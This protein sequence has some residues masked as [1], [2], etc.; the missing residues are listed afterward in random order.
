MA[1][2]YTQDQRIGSLDTPL[3]Q[4]VLVLLSFEGREVVNEGFEYKVEALYNE[5]T[6]RGKI[7][8]FD[9]AI[10]KHCTL[11]IKTRDGGLRFIDGIL[12]EARWLDTREEGDRY[13]LVLRS[14]LWVL[15]KR[16]NSLIFHDKTAPDIITEIFGAH[17]GIA[18]FR[19]A[20]TKSYPTL[21]YV[22]QYRES[23]RDFVCRL[24]EEHG[25]SLHFEHS[26][27]AHKLVMGDSTSAYKDM[28]ARTF[29]AVDRQ[30]RRAEEHFSLWRPERKFTSGKVALNDYDFKKPSANM[31]ADKTGDARFEHGK[32]E[33]YDYPGRYVEQGHG[34]DYAQA[35]L[36]HLRAEDGRFHAEGDAI[37]LF[38]GAMVALRGHP[39]ASQ[40]QQYLVLSVNQSFTGESYRSG[41]GDAAEY[42]GSY[43]LM[44]AD[45]PFAPLTKSP[46]PVARGPQTAKVVGDG[47]IDCDK[48]GRILIRFHWDRKSDQSRRVRVA[49]V[50][51]GSG[52][53]AI[54]TPRVGM[55]VLVDFLEG[56]PDQPI[57]VGCVYNSENMPPF[58]LPGSKNIS[59]WKS[60]S[61]TGGGGYNEL[62]MD[63][64]KGS[65]LVRMHAQYDLDS[66]IEHDETRKIKNNRDTTIDQNDTLT[67]KNE[68][69]IDVTSKITIT[70]GKSSITMDPMSIKIESPNI[71]LAATMSLKTS[72]KITAQHEATANMTISGLIVKIN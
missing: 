9:K 67:I 29:V 31:K 20:L 26:Q 25:I 50:Q 47:E 17:G 44:R 10:G 58:G 45:R 53:G 22:A 18:D 6:R 30:H 69:K 55:E 51:A 2:T 11:R 28:G 56:D 39:D 65:E 40:N 64:T 33:V 13:E 38:P 59:G 36:D 46:K 12:A 21:E 72:S 23:D 70:C 5:G 63:D 48:W 14:W 41:S 24:A 66:T 52:W 43:E 8:D 1:K 54:F 35:R 68:L 3:G 15:S 62:V 42:R 57:V 27:G 49:Q 16:I 71:E 7:I 61:T 4:D 37:S 32:L 60:N 19:N 34:N